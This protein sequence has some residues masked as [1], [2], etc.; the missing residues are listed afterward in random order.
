M[1]DNEEKLERLE[2]KMATQYEKTIVARDVS[3]RDRKSLKSQSSG[4]YEVSVS[5]VN[6]EE[7]PQK[8]LSKVPAQHIREL[9]AAL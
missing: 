5:E 1:R 9:Q 6:S 7:M 3:R 2:R 8:Q 4:S